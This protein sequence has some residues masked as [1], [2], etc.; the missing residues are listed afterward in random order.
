MCGICGTLIFRNIV[1]ERSHIEAMCRT[2]IHRGPDDQGVYTALHIGLGQRRLAIIDLNP[3]ATAPIP[4]EDETIW[5]ILNGEIYNYQGLRSFLETKG[6]SFRTATDTEVL[7]HLYEEYGKTCLQKIKGM[8]A[9]AL[10][11]RNKGTLFA[12]RDRFGKKPFY[13][14]INEK[15]LVFGSEIKALTYSPPFSIAPNY[16]A[17]DQY[18]THSYVPSPLT[19][20]EGIYK[21]RPGTY[22]TCSIGGNFEVE[23]YWQPSRIF[24]TRETEYEIQGELLRLLK[25]SVKLRMISDVPLGAFL[26]GGVDSSTIVALM[27]M[28][29]SQPVKTFAIGFEEGDINELP[30]AR[31]IAQRYGTDHHEFIVKPN[32]LEILPELVKHYS[33]PFADSSAIPTYYVSKMTRNYVTVS[34]SGDGCD[35]ILSGYES[36]GILMK[37]HHFDVIPQELRRMIADAGHSILKFFPYNNRAC[38]INRGFTML[39]S[40]LRDRYF[41]HGTT[42]KPEEKRTTYT[43]NFHYLLSHSTPI[44]LLA[45]Y[46]WNK[47][48]DVLDWLMNHDLSFYLPDCL[49]VKVDV[50]SMANSLEVR[51]PFLDHK[52]VE[53]AASIP[54]SMK[55][56]GDSGK[57]IFKKAVAHLLPNEVLTKRK[58]GFS[59]PLNRWFRGKD[60]QFLKEILLDERSTK[61][62][63]F[64]GKMIKKMIQEHIEERRDWTTRLWAF[65]CL[66]L[67][68]REFID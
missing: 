29:S 51:C 50:A 30:F 31:L 61:R 43:P 52:L 27:A 54:S 62:D 5:V 14:S 35:E 64:N 32:A 23:Q 46:P 53:Y 48:Q 68:F 10:W 25:E 42:L 41:L 9:F 49:M 55:R 3:R 65:L 36:Y 7:V 6:H 12:A 18:L 15:G 60:G 56:V 13:Y 67:W 37:W 47:Y 11:D 38:Q 34:L 40:N 58:T 66:E 4:N 39:G 8:F 20:F 28:Q 22:L 57:V 17:I 16:Y 24:K 19:A 59:I 45:L 21:L 2:L 33:E 26:S 1:P 44:D 63:L